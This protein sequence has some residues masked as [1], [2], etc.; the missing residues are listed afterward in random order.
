VSK[1]QW[2]QFRDLIAPIAKDGKPLL[3]RSLTNARNKVDTLN[4]LYNYDPRVAPWK[5]TAHGV[6]QA[7]NT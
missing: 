3:G 7:V 2:L 5:D 4:K 6:L 1:E